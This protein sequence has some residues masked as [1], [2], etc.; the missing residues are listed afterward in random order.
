MTLNCTGSIS[1]DLGVW[2]MWNASSIPLLTELLGLEVLVLLSVP[3]T[4]EI[5][6]LV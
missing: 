5:K 3:S 4:G 1:I 6:L 2:G